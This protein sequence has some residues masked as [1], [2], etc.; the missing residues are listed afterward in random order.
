MLRTFETNHDGR[1]KEESV[2]ESPWDFVPK[3]F[4]CTTFQYQW[5]DIALTLVRAMVLGCRPFGV[6]FLV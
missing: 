5:D 1:D 6:F 3:M 4:K 2:V